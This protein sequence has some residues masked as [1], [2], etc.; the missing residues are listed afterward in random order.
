MSSVKRLQKTTPN[1]SFLSSWENKRRK[2]QGSTPICI[3]LNEQ[4]LNR[5]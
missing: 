1:P 4:C 5:Q 2:Q 3:R